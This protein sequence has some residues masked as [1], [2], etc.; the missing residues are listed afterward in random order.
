[1]CWPGKVE[2]L[3][4]AVPFMVFQACV[5]S[6][7]SQAGEQQSNGMERRNWSSPGNRRFRGSVRSQRKRLAGHSSTSAG[8][9]NPNPCAKG[10]T[11]MSVSVTRNSPAPQ[12]GPRVSMGSA[13]E[14]E[15]AVLLH[16]A[17]SR[18]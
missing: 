9:G 13:Q 6:I 4:A 11:V 16:P 5:L 7:V 15:S 17:L 3:G 14:L 2:T 12:K 18:G 8:D 1:M 10:D